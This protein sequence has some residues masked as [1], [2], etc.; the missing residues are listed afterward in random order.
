M[1]AASRKRNTQILESL[2]PVLPSGVVLRV[3]W[4]N[5]KDYGRRTAF[6][7]HAMNIMGHEHPFLAYDRKGTD[8][9]TAKFIS[10][11][12]A[13]FFTKLLSRCTD[14]QATVEQVL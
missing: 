8:D 2:P 7:I 5:W 11:N 3:H 12:D 10:D 1:S 4:H 9:N 13:A 14:G 6:F